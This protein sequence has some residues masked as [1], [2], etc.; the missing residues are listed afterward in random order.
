MIA[1]SFSCQTCQISL[2][3]CCHI[4]ISLNVRMTVMSTFG[5]YCM[6]TGMTVRSVTIILS[7]LDAKIV[8]I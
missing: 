4:K 2:S 8:H 5:G 3:Y 6:M 1:R 7:G